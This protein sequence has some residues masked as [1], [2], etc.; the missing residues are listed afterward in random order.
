MWSEYFS[1]VL[2]RNQS[3]WKRRRVVQTEE[4]ATTCALWWLESRFV[5]V[6]EGSTQR[7]KPATVSNLNVYEFDNPQI[8][9]LIKILYI[10]FGQLICVLRTFTFSHSLS[11]LFLSLFTQ[12]LPYPQLR[13]SFSTLDIFSFLF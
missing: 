10:I 2:Q 9:K 13:L 12:C 11:V 6:T 8:K 1:F 3:P 7:E 5:P 4:A